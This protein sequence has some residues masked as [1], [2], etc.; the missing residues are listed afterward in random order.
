[1]SAQLSHSKIRGLGELFSDAW[2]I[3]I[4]NI[5]LFLEVMAVMIVG[6]LAIILILFIPSIFMLM[7][8]GNGQINQ[9]LLILGVIL[10]AL[11]VLA[12]IFWSIVGTI[13][14]IIAVK[15]LIDGR[16]VTLK[17]VY[18]LALH[19]FWPIL[20]LSI[21]VGFS[22]FIGLILLIIPGIILAVWFY[23]SVYVYLD[24]EK[25]LTHS[26][27]KSKRLVGDYWWKLFG[28]L[29]LISLLSGVISQVTAI[30]GYLATPFFILITFLLYR[31]LKKL[32]G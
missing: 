30:I 15:K 5:V 6:M 4:K 25:G 20:G 23:F 12:L 24:E 10:M 9:I 32:R 28:I 18:V 26:M 7:F 27:I 29:I 11:A 1:M 14:P 2:R 13:A 22:V 8:S 17:Q 16:S 19:Y 21:L 3:Y 31:D